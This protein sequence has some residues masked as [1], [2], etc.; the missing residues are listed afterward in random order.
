MNKFDNT[1]LNTVSPKAGAVKLEIASNKATGPN[2]DCKSCLVKYSGTGPVTLNIDDTA[3]V[4]DF[5]I[6]TSPIPVPISNLNKLNF[7][8]ATNGDIIYILWRT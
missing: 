1:S 2:I 5:P 4:N 7:Y 6:E 8:S 3:D